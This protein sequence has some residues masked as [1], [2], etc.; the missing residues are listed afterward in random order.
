MKENPTQRKGIAIWGTTEEKETIAQFFC[1]NKGVHPGVQPRIKVRNH[2]EGAARD[3]FA[4]AKA[5]SANGTF[6]QQLVFLCC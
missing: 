4:E 5:F 1:V 3:R 2:N 6:G